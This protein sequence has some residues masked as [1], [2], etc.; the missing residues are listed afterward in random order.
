M[1]AFDGVTTAL[2]MEIGAPDVA[3]F[4]KSKQGHSLIHYGTT[5]SHVAARS[6]V[7]GAPL[8]DGTDSAKKW[9]R[10]RSTRHA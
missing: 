9:T 4:L 2:E 6:L 1:K 7:F 3:Q 5:A 10:H 8:P